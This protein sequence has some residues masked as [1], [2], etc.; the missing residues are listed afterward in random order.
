MIDT[1][2][3]PETVRAFIALKLD[4]AV[5]AAITALI[6]RLK[7]PDDGI[8]WVRPSNFHLTLFFL[9][10]AV[11]RERLVPVAYALEE[12]A[13]E[14]AP[15]DLEVRGAGVLPDAARPRVLW[16]GLHAPELIALAGRV[17]EAAERCGFQ[18][19]RRGY[20]PHLTIARVRT[21]RAW[22][23]LRPKFEAVAALRF[24]VSRVERLVLYR[25]EPGPQA[26]TY[27]ELAVFPFGGGRPAGVAGEN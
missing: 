20:L 23:A 8:R 13:A 21:P 12:I 22:R 27:T 18:R 14:T 11:I 1:A 10:P 24:G 25:S 15:F 17:A 16:V 19:E 9:G 7:A 6:D 2:A 5:E 26:S 3:L 4:P